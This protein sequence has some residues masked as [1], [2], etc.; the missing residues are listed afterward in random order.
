MKAVILAGGFGTRLSEETLVKPKPMV[1]VGGM[2]ILWHIMKIY[3]HHDI[4]EFII[5]LGYRG[6]Q[7]KEFF[8]NFWMRS[9]DITFHLRSGEHLSHK[10]C[11]EDWTV[12]LVETG[13]QA[14]T[15]GRLKRVG[16]FLKE[17]DCFCCTYGDGVADVDITKSIQFHRSHKKLATV[18]GV[19]PPGRFGNL[20]CEDDV[21]VGFD[22]KP[23]GDGSLING[24]FFVLSP[25]VFELIDGDATVWEQE[26]MATM[27]ELDQLRVFK[28]N[29]FWHPM[30]TLRDKSNLERMWL[31]GNAPWVTW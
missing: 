20:V 2:P 8:A 18:T 30:D 12:R 7:I 27:V 17:D 15:G 16:E 19:Y 13:D 14:M 4:N 3:A 24:G 23:K 25:D 6:H 26:P 21:V 31:S 5:C 28:H 9:D 1:E 29:G 10:S 11:G 22:E